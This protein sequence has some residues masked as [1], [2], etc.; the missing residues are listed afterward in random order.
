MIEIKQLEKALSAL[1]KITIELLE[2]QYIGVFA[3]LINEWV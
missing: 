1:R 2:K 3:T